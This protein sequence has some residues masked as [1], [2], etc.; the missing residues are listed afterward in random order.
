LLSESSIVVRAVEFSACIEDS[1]SASS[2]VGACLRFSDLSC[3]RRVLRSFAAAERASWE[4]MVSCLGRC[5]RGDCVDGVLRMIPRTREMKSNQGC[6]SRVR[7][8]GILI[9]LYGE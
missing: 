6:V 7:F 5:A 3:A 8:C 4:D 2:V 9:A 1:L